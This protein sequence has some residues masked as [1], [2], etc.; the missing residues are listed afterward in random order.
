MMNTTTA[1]TST[2]QLRGAF[3]ATLSKEA[4]AAFLTRICSGTWT[5]ESRGEFQSLMES[6]WEALEHLQHLGVALTDDEL[7][8]ELDEAEGRLES[9]ISALYGDAG[10]Y[11]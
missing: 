6:A 3:E 9:R 7:I 10:E 5:P 8:R 4:A 1:A 11:C 2:R